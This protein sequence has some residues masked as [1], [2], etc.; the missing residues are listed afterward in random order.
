MTKIISKIINIFL[1][2]AILCALCITPVTAEPAKLV[3]DAPTNEVTIEDFHTK[4]VNF[5]L[6]SNWSER[7]LYPFYKYSV[8]DEKCWKS[9]TPEIKEKIDSSYRGKLVNHKLEKKIGL[10]PLNKVDQYNLNKLKEKLAN[11]GWLDK[12][13][14][15]SGT[16]KLSYT[17]NLNGDNKFTI[18]ATFTPKTIITY[19]N[20]FKIHTTD[21]KEII[22]IDKQFDLSADLSNDDR[23]YIELITKIIDKHSSINDIALLIEGAVL[24]TS[25]GTTIIS[26]ASA[27]LTVGTTTV[28]CAI[29]IISTT[30]SGGLLIKDATNNANIKTQVAK[31]LNELDFSSIQ[32]RDE[33]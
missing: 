1:I 21:Q 27:P 22:L 15:T 10:I 17:N 2:F 18:K 6:N 26:C 9:L 12:D 4:I 30:T 8:L 7:T 33:L 3:T 25:V 19:N 13:V 24:I 20:K 14:Y 23:N 31:N 11:Q 5:A 28:I 16:L 29:G 32:M